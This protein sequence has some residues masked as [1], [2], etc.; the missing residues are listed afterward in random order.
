ML[1]L[2]CS[3]V[4]VYATELTFDYSKTFGDE[5]CCGYGYLV[6]VLNPLLVVNGYD[7]IKQVHGTFGRGVHNC[8]VDGVACVAF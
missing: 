5:F 8:E 1:A 6:A 7:F 2:I 3:D 4:F